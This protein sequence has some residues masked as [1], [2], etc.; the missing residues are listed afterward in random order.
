MLEDKDKFK[1]ND[2]LY[3]HNF[4]PNKVGYDR[5]SPIRKFGSEHYLQV[6]LLGEISKQMENSNS[7]DIVL[8]VEGKKLNGTRPDILGWNPSL[9]I[10][11]PHFIIEIKVTGNYL[12]QNTKKESLEKE[13]NMYTNMPDETLFFFSCYYEKARF[14]IESFLL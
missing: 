3:E 5:N 7:K 9:G 4:H 6:M 14:F 8:S 1:N 13:I 11:K 2:Q 10:E 12:L